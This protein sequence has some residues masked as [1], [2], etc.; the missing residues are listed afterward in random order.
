[1]APAHTPQRSPRQGARLFRGGS[2]IRRRRDANGKARRPRGRLGRLP[3]LQSNNKP[4]V[5]QQQ[6][7]HIV[8]HPER[9]RVAHD[10]AVRGGDDALRIGVVH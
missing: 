2:L 6:L 10:V 5:L 9:W 4:R 8:H 1:M 3:H 7:R